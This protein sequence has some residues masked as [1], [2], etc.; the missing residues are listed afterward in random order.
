[1]NF[2][3]Y[4]ALHAF[5]E[6]GSVAQA[7][8]RL[9]RTQPQISR[10][11]AQLEDE[12][13]FPILRKSGRRLQLTEEG[14]QFYQHV[15]RL[16]RAQDEVQDFTS[17]IRAGVRG[18]VRILAA[19]HI[20]DGL[21]LE[22]M[23][24]CSLQRPGF[25]AALNARMPADL[26]W[27]LAQQQFDVALVQLPLEHPAVDTHCFIESDIVAVLH[28]D[29]PLAGQARITAKQ[30]EQHP[31]VTLGSR[32]I[33]SQ[34]C[35]ASFESARAKPLS[36]LETSFSTSSVQLAAMGCGIALAEPF[37]ALRQKTDQV[38]LRAFH[39][40]VRLRY[41]VVYPKQREPGESTLFFVQ[42]LE[43][44]AATQQAQLVALLGSAA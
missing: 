5:V 23:G 7:A 44:V 10:L 4:E 9:Y 36:L 12:A 26:Q 21:A 39:P 14:Q 22:A 30:L 42:Q 31:Y 35:H 15:Y 18:R 38:V 43:A 6:G 37:S 2:K 19:N 11:L 20:I 34:K 1:M 13:G 8:L 24:R 32:S 33:L 16:L 25:S 28:V 3:A 40:R 17:D 41:G 29:H 27:W